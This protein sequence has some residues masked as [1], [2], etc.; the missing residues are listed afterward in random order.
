MGGGTF[1]GVQGG[2][3]PHVSRHLALRA[4]RRNRR[5]AARHRY[6]ASLGIPE[7]SVVDLEYLDYARSKYLALGMKDTMP[8]K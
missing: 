1:Q 2:G 3:T 5:D 8:K 4:A 7:S 6:L